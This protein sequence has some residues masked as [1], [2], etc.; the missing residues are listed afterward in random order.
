VFGRSGIK[1]SDPNSNTS[2]ETGG[3][4][5][6]L[7][8]RLRIE[9]Y[10]IKLRTTVAM[11]IVTFWDVMQCELVTDYADASKKRSVSEIQKPSYP[12]VGKVNSSKTP[13]NY[14]QTGSQLKITFANY[15]RRIIVTVYFAKAAFTPPF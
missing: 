11:K 5:K 14:Y 1:L 9:N 6:Y 3:K 13:I 15:L 12:E 10:E 2:L 7:A 8:I 4:F